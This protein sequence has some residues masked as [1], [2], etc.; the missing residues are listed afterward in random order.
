MAKKTD[1]V[2]GKGIAKRE[3]KL[4]KQRK[5]ALAAE[6]D[7]QRFQRSDRRSLARLQNRE[8]GAVAA[9]AQ[10]APDPSAGAL[11]RQDTIVLRDDPLPTVEYNLAGHASILLSLAAGIGFLLVAAAFVLE[12]GLLA[13]QSIGGLSPVGVPAQ[14]AQIVLALDTLFPVFFGAGLGVLLTSV[15][16]RGNRPLIR[17]ALTALLVAVIA[18]FAENAL[19]FN[20]MSGGEIDAAQGV[21]TV[22]KYAGLA[23]VA[24]MASAV[25]PSSG[26]LGQLVHVLVRYV[27]PVAIAVLLS[28]LGGET[29]R[30][31]IG[32]GFPVILMVL[33]LFAAQMGEPAKA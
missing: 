6:A 8:L 1:A 11:T 17:L 3:K 5:K 2:S 22:I 9:P 26:F 27:F 30:Q 29:A 23:L 28:G 10:A 18:D 16:A 15:Q 4:A 12:S 31:A 20:T 32:A 14:T 21:L 7:N 33:A 13:V 24:V 25:L 19:V